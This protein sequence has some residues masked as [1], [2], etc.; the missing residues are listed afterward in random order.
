MRNKVKAKSVASGAFEAIS[1][2]LN[3]SVNMTHEADTGSY[4]ILESSAK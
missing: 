2:W 4:E 1:K 3:Q